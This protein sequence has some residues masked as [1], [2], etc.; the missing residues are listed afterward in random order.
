MTLDCTFRN[1]LQPRVISVHSY[2]L[3]SYGYLSFYWI[4][5]RHVLFLFRNISSS[6]CYLDPHLGP[7]PHT[8]GAGCWIGSWSG[9]N[10]GMRI[11]SV[12]LPGQSRS[13]W[14][15]ASPFL[16]QVSLLGLGSFPLVK[17][18]AVILHREFRPCVFCRWVLFR[19]GLS[20]IWPCKLT[21]GAGTLLR[22]LDS[23]FLVIM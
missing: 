8:W 10:C 13:V 14:L 22:T 3:T 1:L 20:T 11:P 6:A 12:K 9:K 2:Y 7:Y 23:S 4:A 17:G 18:P 5:T 19:N 21:S 15:S 16:G